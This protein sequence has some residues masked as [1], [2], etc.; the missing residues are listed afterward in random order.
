VGI[1]TNIHHVVHDGGQLK[2]QKPGNLWP[3]T[4]ILICLRFAADRRGCQLQCSWLRHEEVLHGS[5]L[6]G[7]VVD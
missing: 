3:S 1:D 2:Q 4:Q 5:Q 7:G 6:I